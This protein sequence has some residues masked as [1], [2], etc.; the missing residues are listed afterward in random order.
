MLVNAE[1]GG[2]IGIVEL[3]NVVVALKTVVLGFIG[4]VLFG[5][6]ECILRRCEH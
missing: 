1:A 6:L 4:T 2:K 3:D 5:A